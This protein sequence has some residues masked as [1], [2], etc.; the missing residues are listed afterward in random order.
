MFKS[1]FKKGEKTVLG[2]D[3]D[4]RKKVT[5]TLAKRSL[6]NMFLYSKEHIS[7]LSFIMPII[8]QDLKRISNYLR[9]VDKGKSNENHEQLGDLTVISDSDS[10]GLNVLV[11]AKL[12]GISEESIA[13]ID[14]LSLQ[15]AGI[16]PLLGPVEEVADV[17]SDIIIGMN[18]SK[19]KGGFLFGEKQRNHLK[20]YIYLLKLHEP[21]DNVT[22]DMLVDMYN[23]PQYVRR[24]F[25]EFKSLYITSYNEIMEDIILDDDIIRSVYEWFEENLL[26]LPTDQWIDG[27]IMYYDAMEEYAKELR[28]YLNELVRHPGIRRILYAVYATEP[29]DFGRHLTEGG[30]LLVNTRSNELRCHSEFIGKVVIMQLHQHLN[31]LFIESNASNAFHHLLIDDH[32]KY[33]FNNFIEFQM[34]SRIYKVINSLL[35]DLAHQLEINPYWMDIAQNKYLFHEQL[36]IEVQGHHLEHVY[37]VIKLI[38]ISSS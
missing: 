25:E 28:T 37:P 7:P 14:P 13:I 33:M 30:V 3:T 8:S 17:L 34:Q 6:N 29:F 27:V 1:L 36:R 35:I 12:K 22:F 9:D 15:T 20:H 2:R 5:A 31:K 11:E 26:P 4:T 38:P 10:I 21:N 24:I 19:D 32:D 23:N 16:N 18:A